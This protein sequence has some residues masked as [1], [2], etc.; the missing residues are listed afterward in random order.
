MTNRF[1]EGEEGKERAEGR[2]NELFDGQM[3]TSGRKH[4]SR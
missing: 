3:D 4:R 1:L 2:V